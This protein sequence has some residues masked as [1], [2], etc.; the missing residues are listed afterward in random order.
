MFPTSAL[1]RVR[2]A[3]ENLFSQLIHYKTTR[4]YMQWPLLYVKFEQINCRT[5]KNCPFQFH[6]DFI[7]IFSVSSLRLIAVFQLFSLTC[8]AENCQ[9]LYGSKS[10]LLL[11]CFLGGNNTAFASFV[12]SNPLNSVFQFVVYN[13]HCLS[14][15]NLFIGHSSG[16]HEL[17]I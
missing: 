7:S 1:S 5:R 9:V 10:E 12:F 14:D 13:P 16:I 11:V 15:S 6:F 4:Y 3:P 2:S 17:P 8:L